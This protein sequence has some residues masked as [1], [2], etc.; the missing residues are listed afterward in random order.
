M[1]KIDFDYDNYSNEELESFAQE[2]NEV[3]KERKEEKLKERK[4]ILLN[5]IINELELFA[6][7]FPDECIFME[8]ESKWLELTS[9][10]LIHELER[11]NKIVEMIE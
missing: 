9:R 7:E 4:K 5:N 6:K 2:I 8:S 1:W 11:Y 10:D 3:L